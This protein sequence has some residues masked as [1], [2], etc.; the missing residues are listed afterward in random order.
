MP[1]SCHHEV[2]MSMVREYDYVAIFHSVHRVMKAEKCLKNAGLDVLLIPAPRQLSADCGLALRYAPELSEKV[3]EL[4]AL[5]RLAP[6]NIYQWAKG[7]Y[8]RI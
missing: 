8:Q 6:G 1:L 2:V 5:E 3:A 7:A 4:L